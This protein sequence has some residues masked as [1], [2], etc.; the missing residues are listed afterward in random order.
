M[1]GLV[2]FPVA[3]RSG[4]FTSSGSEANATGLLLALTRRFPYFATDGV[5][6]LPA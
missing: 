4:H 6:G 5:R 1:A 3:T 2:G